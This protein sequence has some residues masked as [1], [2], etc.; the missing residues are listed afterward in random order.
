MWIIKITQIIKKNYQFIIGGLIFA[1]FVSLFFYLRNVWNGY[2]NYK[3]S[4]KQVRTLENRLDSLRAVNY[5]QLND[6]SIVIQKKVA[7]IKDLEVDLNIKGS[8]IKE[9]QGIA[10]KVRDKYL[11]DYRAL[12]DSCQCPKCPKCIGIKIK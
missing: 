7:Q 6:S 8:Q 5:S 12:K 9:L 2:N 1:F 3:E 11:A 10:K 4:Q